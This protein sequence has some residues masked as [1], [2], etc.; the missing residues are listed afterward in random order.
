MMSTLSLLSAE[1]YLYE[2]AQQ[3]GRSAY[4]AILENAPD[5]EPDE[6]DKL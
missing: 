2:R 5:V 4:L 1:S 6:Q 3:G